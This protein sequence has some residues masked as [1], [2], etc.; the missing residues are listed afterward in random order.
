[1]RLLTSTLIITLLIITS[2]NLLAQKAK[3]TEEFKVKTS[4]QCDMC[5]ERLEKAM[6]YEKGVKKSNLNVE[7]AVL[8]IVYNP[9]KTTPKII[10]KAISDVGYDADEIPADSNAY[11]NLPSCCKKGGM[12]H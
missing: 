4:A 2:N 11:N 8:T 7:K 6:A 12:D 9:K 10:R 5:K 3:K 1:M